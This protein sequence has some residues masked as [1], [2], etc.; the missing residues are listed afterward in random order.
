[1]GKSIKRNRF[2]ILLFFVFFIFGTVTAFAKK[3]KSA[4]V[5]QEEGYYY[6]F[7]KGATLEEAELA[8]KRDLVESALTATLRAANPKASRIS[9]SDESVKAR[10][11]DLKPFSKSKPK[12]APAVTYRIKIVDWDKREKAYADNLRND[13]T[14]RFN[15]AQGKS[16]AADKIKGAID[17][18][19]E[20]I[21]EGETELLTAKE[22]G[23]ELFAHRLEA[24]CVQV[25][26]KLVI[27][28]SIK[29]GFVNPSTSFSVKVTDTSDNAVAG[30]PLSV[31]WEIADLPSDAAATDVPEVRSSGKTDAL[32]YATI[33]YPVSEDYRNRPVILNVATSFAQF[34]PSS[35]ALKKADTQSSVDAYYVHVD[36]MDAAYPSVFVSEGEFNAGAV[37][38]DTRAGKKEASRL[39]S[40]AS[41]AIDVYPVTNARYAAFLHITRA[42]N[43]PEYFYNNDFNQGSQPVVGLTVEEAEAYAAWLSEQTGFTYRLPTE[44]EWE[45]AA[46]AGTETVYPWGD[47]SPAAEK[48]ANYKGNG[49]FTA[50]SPVGSF[51]NGKNAWGLADMAGNVWE[52]TASVHGIDGESNLRT[53]KGGSWMDGPVELRIS[54]FRNID[55][56]NGYTD[57]G[58]RLVKEVSE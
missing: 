43:I 57:V 21:A 9:V 14:A 29:D 11:A 28:F 58:F 36:D 3:P 47:D 48:K 46:R 38:Q 26:K 33:D 34:L 30:V 13:L 32:G 49:T 31:I 2:L 24:F 4:L 56:Q 15:A 27:T 41:Y 12:E 20:L 10:L 1:M 17:I 23:T 35:A 50:P 42:E 25:S 7:G 51:E 54:N 40:T 5:K 44:E 52:W 19:A 18:L 55:A 37:A 16:G 45:K 6:G 53:V 22:S 8:G 39:V